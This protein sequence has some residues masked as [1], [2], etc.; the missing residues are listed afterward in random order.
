M[1]S[2]FKPSGYVS[3]GG[4]TAAVDNAPSGLAF[5][6]KIAGSALAS[7]KSETGEVMQG[8]VSLAALMAIILLG[9]GFY[10][11][12]RSVQGGG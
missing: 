12:T 6:S 9:M 3:R 11:A 10:Y 5:P 4:N 7:V 8:R 1:G 2:P